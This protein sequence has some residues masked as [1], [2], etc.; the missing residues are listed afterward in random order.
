MYQPVSKSPFF[1]VLA[2]F[3]ILAT[4]LAQAAESYPLEPHPEK[5]YSNREP[6][7]E[8]LYPNREPSAAELITDVVIVRPLGIV[9]TVVGAVFY[10]IALPFSLPSGSADQ[11][12]EALVKDPAK[13]TFQRPLGNFR[14]AWAPTEQNEMASRRDEP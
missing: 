6:Y 12:A 3:L 8:E 5:P 10:V 4:S 1:T 11:A 9:A 13:Y 7:S 2:A 14:S